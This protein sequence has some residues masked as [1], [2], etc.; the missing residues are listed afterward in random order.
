MSKPLK[1]RPHHFLCLSFYEGKGYNKD[2]V[3]NFDKLNKEVKEGRR[4]LIVGANTNDNLCKA[5]P[6]NKETCQKSSVKLIDSRVKEVLNL[7]SFQ[8]WSWEKVQR[9]IKNNLTIDKLIYTC[10]K[11]RWIEI[12]KRKLTEIIK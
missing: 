10:E 3:N 8:V 5:C 7:K 1:I 12:C 4:K 2:F 6:H 11:C 9:E